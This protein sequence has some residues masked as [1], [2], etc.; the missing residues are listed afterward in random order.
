MIPQPTRPQQFAVALAIWASY[1]SVVGPYD[2][3]AAGPQQPVVS[4]AGT[5]VGQPAT[6][7]P[8]VEAKSDEQVESIPP[9]QRS[10][11]VLP[12]I[13]AEQIPQG[14]LESPLALEEVL[15][16]V[17][18]SYPLLEAAIRDASVAE[19]EALAAYGAYDVQVKAETFTTAMGFYQATLSTAGVEQLS[20]HAG[21][22]LYAG[23]K[24]GRG[25]F[26][27]WDGDKV[28]NEGGE[29]QL[30][31][32][33]PLLQGRAIDKPRAEVQKT[34]FARRAI[35]P[36]IFKA[37]LDFAKQ[38]SKAYWTWVAEGQRFTIAMRLLQ[39]A[40]ERAAQLE[41]LVEKGVVA[42]VEQID[43]QRVVYA[44]QAAVVAAERR[45]QQAAIELSLFIRDEQGVPLLAPA[46]R[47]PPQF[48]DPHKPDPSRIDVDVAQALAMRPELRVLRY[49]RMK[50]EVEYRLA[51]NLQL[52]KLGAGLVARQDV[53]EPSSDKRDK[54]PFQLDAGVQMGVPLQRREAAGR[55]L[56]A[57]QAIASLAAQQRYL[58][59]RITAD[60][61]DAVS[62]LVA[63]YERRERALESRAVAIQVLD[64]ERERFRLGGGTLLV[65]N[66]REL[67][68]ADAQALE[69][70]SLA[71]FYRALADYLAALAVA[72]GTRA[73]SIDATE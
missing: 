59:D 52:P 10:P 7:A 2:L 68:V 73:L 70:D 38:A 27:V 48:P 11:Q 22:R 44:R 40:E 13:A 58:E 8:R 19:G 32:I 49:E 31:A 69:V 34:E 67:A 72:P 6:P 29:F 47:L 16:R 37:R 9:P 46:A 14:P 65:L 41:V 36:K 5:A 17:E 39:L 53:G 24:L 64:R 15:A 26:A 12:G 3:H 23:Y 21:E 56:A 63:A 42:E 55:M 71:D 4:P 28:T 60:V 1:V 35:A 62:A 30:G 43:N 54:S 33:V 18:A 50:L 25:N 51:D 20:P 57:Q 66:L 61:R 45:F